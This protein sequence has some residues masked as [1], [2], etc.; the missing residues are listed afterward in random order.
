ML[1]LK[2][3]LE[4]EVRQ[5]E[6][7]RAELEKH[8]ELKQKLSGRISVIERLKTSQKG[9]VLLMNGVISSIPQN[10][11]LW[12]S[13]LAQRE[14]LVTIEGRAFDLDSVADFIARLDEIPLF[15]RV[16]LN[17]LE[18]DESSVLFALSCELL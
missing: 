5:L 15:K 9:P 3:E 6:V 11:T 2:E 10:P 17:H 16:E 8:E 12:L 13:S 4:Q 14:N 1:A 18:E 7:V